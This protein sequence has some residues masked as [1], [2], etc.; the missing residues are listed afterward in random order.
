MGLSNKV[1]FL[2]PQLFTVLI[3]VS[4]FNLY[5][6]V[7][8][9]NLYNLSANTAARHGFK[10]VI[11]F[12]CTI[13]GSGDF[14]KKF[15]SRNQNW[16]NMIWKGYPLHGSGCTAREI[17]CYQFLNNSS[18]QSHGKPLRVS[19][20]T[21]STSVSLHLRLHA[22]LGRLCPRAFRSPFSRLSLSLS[23]VYK[24]SSFRK[25]TS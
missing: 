16:G 8:F 18:S 3:L 19:P 12:D 21:Y 7:S 10:R 24:R 2:A 23:S 9:L 22:F 11:N 15:I 4:T 20:S 6:L 1:V 5:L 13:G 14:S 25:P 17:A